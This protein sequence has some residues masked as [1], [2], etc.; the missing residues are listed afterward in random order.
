MQVTNQSTANQETELLPKK[1]LDI[2]LKWSKEVHY[3]CRLITGLSGFPH[4]IQLQGCFVAHSTGVRRL[5]LVF[6]LAASLAS[7]AFASNLRFIQNPA[8]INVLG[9]T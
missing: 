1:V 9:E 8:P 5:A 6:A 3:V 7:A 2:G 4:T